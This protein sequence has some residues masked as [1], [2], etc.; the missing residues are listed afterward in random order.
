MP[1]PL[2]MPSA[3]LCYPLGFCSPPNF[4]PGTQVAR[5][6]AMRNRKKQSTNHPTAPL[7]DTWTIV[8]GVPIY[9]R[10]NTKAAP[11][12]QPTIVLVHGF[13]IS[14]RYM[15]PV[16]EHLA[17]YFPVY[18]PDLPGFGNSGEPGWALDLDE[19]ADALAR[20]MEVTG[21][22]SAVLLGNSLG[23]QIIA[24][25]AA[26]HPDR[27]ERAILVG[28]T[29]DPEYRTAPQQAALLL[30]DA[31]L[32]RIS[33]WA[34]HIADYF[35]AG[36]RRVLKT[37]RYT[38]ADQIETFLPKMRIPTLVVR[39]ERDPVVPQRWAETVT[40]LLPMG[41]LIVIHGGAHTGNYSTPRDLTR[42]VRAF[43]ADDWALEGE[44]DV[45][46]LPRATSDVEARAS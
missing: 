26:R 19:L 6:L 32:E 23:C 40:D 1:R 5:L 30:L 34:L 15:V 33:V 7:Q 11:P 3:S 42:I 14:S 29:V 46:T 10:V 2:A 18:A 21:I 22:P 17:P 44:R 31:P 36:I 8:D 35:K 27:I 38:L 41:R 45:G 13:I 16:A 39:G 12:G 24:H 20:W 28:P 9:A 43:L 4:P 37:M 25:F